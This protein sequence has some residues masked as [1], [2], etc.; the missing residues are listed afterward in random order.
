MQ[1]TLSS[2][3]GDGA[4]QAMMAQ[5]PPTSITVHATDFNAAL[6]ACHTEE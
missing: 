6:M 3:S 2:S 1:H 4:V 5:P